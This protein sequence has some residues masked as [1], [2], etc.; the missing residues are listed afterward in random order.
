[1]VR[2]GADVARTGPRT[3]RAV[4][5]LLPPSEGKTAGA[6]PPLQP[7]TLSAA[8]LGAARE[9][10][11]S[12][13]VRLC[14]RRDPEP[15]RTA[16]GLSAGQL[17]EVARNAGLREAPTAPAGQVYTGVLFDALG[18]A[19]LPPPARAA[20]ES[21]VRVCSGLWGV[22]RL[23]DRIPAYRCPISARLPRLGGLAAYWRGR[24]PRTMTAAAGDRVVLDLRS[25]AYA[26]AWAPGPELAARTVTVRVL[27]ERI[28]DG[29]ARRTVVSHFN[30][31]VKGRLVRDLALCGAQ[32]SS[33][34]ELVE[35]LGQL[36]YR[37]AD[38]APAARGGRRL[39]VIVADPA[40][41]LRTASAAR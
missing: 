20:L 29:V 9:R 31:A 15:A 2:N 10:V 16:L 4:L 40:D 24:L 35:L 38:A 7:A 41:T 11:L 5:I 1:M 22:L 14:A 23:D 12:A 28:V 17:A 19:T 18:L 32:P 8:E 21:S 3:V 34:A 26:A 39:D 13:L 25:G 37:L 36:G 30:K 27:H 6:G 33:P